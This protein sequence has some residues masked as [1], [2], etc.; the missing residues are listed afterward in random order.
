MVNWPI[1]WYPAFR[2]AIELAQGGAIGEVTQVEYRAA[3]H[4][5]KE[6]GCSPYFY[7]WLY[8]AR[9]NGGGVLADYCCYGALAAHLLLGVPQ[10]VQATAGRYQ[11]DYIEVEDNA[12]LTLEYPRAHAIAQASWSQIGP[13]TGHN[14]VIYG[15]TG[16]ILVH[17]RPGSREGHVIREGTIE[18]M[19]ADAPEGVIVEPPPLA[20]GDRNAVEHIAAHLRDGRPLNAVVDARRSR[21]V[22]QILEAGY[23]AAATGAGVALPLAEVANRG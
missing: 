10:R 17:Q 6:Y 15:T 2:H 7:E 14:P 18:L 20:L 5:P 16:T 21:D 8:D 3:H 23:R 12:V 9:R 13:G 4:G 11:K 22:Q 1:A 19:T